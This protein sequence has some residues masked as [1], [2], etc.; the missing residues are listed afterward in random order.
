MSGGID[1]M[2]VRR[3]THTATPTK[4]LVMRK[5]ASEAAAFVV[6]EDFGVPPEARHLLTEVEADTLDETA[7]RDQLALL[8][9][10][11]LSE[12]V[13]PDDPVIDDTWALWSAALDRSGDP[14]L[15]WTLTL[16]ALLQ[17]VRMLYL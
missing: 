13:P 8:H 2:S 14:A 17:D 12:P 6:R 1:S 3:P 16:S 9:A 11:V 7:V 15:A 10:R 4:L 5:F